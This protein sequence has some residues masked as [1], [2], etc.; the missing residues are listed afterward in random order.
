[1]LMRQNSNSCK[2]VIV[3]SHITYSHAQKLRLCSVVIHNMVWF[4]FALLFL[5]W[6]SRM[7]NLARIQPGTGWGKRS[8]RDK[9]ELSYQQEK[10]TSHFRHFCAY[11]PTVKL[12]MAIE[13]LQLHNQQATWNQQLHQDFATQLQKDPLFFYFRS[14]KCYSKVR[15]CDSKGHANINT[16]NTRI[17]IILKYYRAV[18]NSEN[19]KSRV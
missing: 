18:P 16:M 8:V 12:T 4:L 10:L 14:S 2:W 11:A 19:I 3:K 1:M 7:C 6:F 5:V 17:Q 15:G 9:H 13:C